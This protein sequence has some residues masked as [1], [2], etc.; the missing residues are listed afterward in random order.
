[1]LEAPVN[2]VHHV[3]CGRYIFVEFWLWHIVRHVVQEIDVPERPSG[4]V[5]GLRSC[6]QLLNIGKLKDLGTHLF[7]HLGPAVVLS[8][9]NNFVHVQQ[10]NPVISVDKVCV[11]NFWR[12][13]GTQMSLHFKKV[14]ITGSVTL[15]GVGARDA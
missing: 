8:W 5:F 4:E 14:R 15:T 6:L 11:R 13:Q 3:Q 1:M 2:M 12:Q 10:C 9:D 7:Q